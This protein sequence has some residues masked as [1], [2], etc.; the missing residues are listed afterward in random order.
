[1]Q[2]NRKKVT[3]LN[4]TAL[5]ARE[6]EPRQVT[7]TL[8]RSWATDRPPDD[9]GRKPAGFVPEWEVKLRDNQRRTGTH[10]GLTPQELRTLRD[11][12]LSAVNQTYDVL[13]AATVRAQREQTDAP[14]STPVAG[15]RASGA[16]LEAADLWRQGSCRSPRHLEISPLRDDVTR[17]TPNSAHRLA[18]SDRSRGDRSAAR[19][20]PQPALTWTTPDDQCRP[21]STSAHPYHRN[22]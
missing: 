9:G 1:M 3:Q 11:I 6:E 15:A 22:R 13:L 7:L 8:R 10:V 18:P 16:A 17:R 21:P 5:S 19:E 20:R 4:S 14:P 12:V 2:V